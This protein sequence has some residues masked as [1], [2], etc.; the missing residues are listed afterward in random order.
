MAILDTRIRW[1]AGRGTC[2]RCGATDTVLADITKIEGGDPVSL[3]EPCM[4]GFE[5]RDSVVRKFVFEH[6]R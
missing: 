6:L 1:K 3:C 4:K 5:A 2:R